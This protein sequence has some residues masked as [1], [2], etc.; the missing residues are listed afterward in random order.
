MTFIELEPGSVETT[1]VHAVTG[2][3]RVLRSA[4]AVGCDGAR[5][6]VRES[7]GIG[8]EGAVKAGCMELPPGPAYSAPATPPNLI[9]PAGSCNSGS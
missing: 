7:L 4:Y 2:E 3:E 9:R 8:Q 6:Q 1:I 5:S